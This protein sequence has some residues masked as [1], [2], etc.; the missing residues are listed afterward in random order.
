MPA[1]PGW[2]ADVLTF[3][4]YTGW[5]RNEILGLDW[6]EVDMRAGMIHLSPARSKNR[7]GRDRPILDGLLPVMQRRVQE[8][9][10][11]DVIRCL[12]VGSVWLVAGCIFCWA[13]GGAAKLG[14]PEDESQNEKSRA[15]DPALD[16]RIHPTEK[17]RGITC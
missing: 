5:R 8:R 13:C 2:A 17:K 10:S 1:L 7:L 3:G 12:I 6:A 14:G 11:D 16:S 15:C 4:Y 9:M